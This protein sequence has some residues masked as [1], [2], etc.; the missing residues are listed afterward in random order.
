MINNTY[1]VISAELI[2]VVCENQA[3]EASKKN[4]SFLLQVKD[5]KELTFRVSG[6]GREGGVAS[7]DCFPLSS[8]LRLISK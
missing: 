4:V 6:K 8:H 5:S 2:C 7:F 3:N 1:E